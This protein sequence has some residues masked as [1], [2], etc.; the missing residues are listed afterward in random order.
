VLAYLAILGVAALATYLFTF[1]VL[2]ASVRWKIVVPPGERRIHERPLPTAGGVAMLGAFL[3]AMAVAWRVPHFHNIFKGASAPIGVVLAAVIIV[4]VGFVDDVK[5]VS[6]PAKIAGEVFACT[7]LFFLGITMFYFRIPFAGFMVLSSDL[8]PLVTVLWVVVIANAV[9][10]IDGLDGLAA[11]IIAIAAGAFCVY[12]QRLSGAGLLSP[13]NIGPL[14]AAIACGVC[15]GFLPHNFHPA[16]I[17]MGDTGALFLGLLMAVSTSVVGGR[18]DNPFSGQTY[19]F[20]APVFIPFLILGVPILDTVFAVFRRAAKR[21]G[22]TTADKQHLHHRL[23]NLGHGQRRAVLIL[24]AWTA[25]LSGFV[26]LPTFTEGNRAN[27]FIPFGV[28]ALGVALYTLFHP[29]I[30]NRIPAAAG[31]TPAGGP[32]TLVVLEDRTPEDQVPA[33]GAASSSRGP[34][35]WAERRRQ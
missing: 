2:W 25:L 31:D 18:I 3:V 30:R 32:P 11:G 24:W 12:G 21:S 6:A 17:I 22:V 13:D 35:D 16:R 14:V 20:F 9:N 23:M 7:P 33:P 8:Q 19:F 28:A 29:G 26:L 1:P 15:I 5:E 4:A 34:F 27:H 10:L